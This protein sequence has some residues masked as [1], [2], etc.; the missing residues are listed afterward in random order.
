M[1]GRISPLGL[2]Y[3]QQSGALQTALSARFGAVNAQ[4]RVAAIF[5]N[6]VHLQTGYWAF[7]TLFRCFM[8]MAV[9]CA[10]AVWFLRTVRGGSAAAAAH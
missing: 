9:G 7:I 5:Y 6:M 3:R 10:I 8:W 2:V 1:T 4:P